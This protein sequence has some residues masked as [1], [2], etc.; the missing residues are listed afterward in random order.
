MA[1]EPRPRGISYGESIVVD[2][3]NVFLLISG[4]WYVYSK[5]RAHVGDGGMGSVLLGRRVADGMPVAIKRIHAEFANRGNVRERVR[6]E[7]QLTFAHP[8]LV[9]ILGCCEGTG[10]KAPIFVISKF[11]H[12]QTID[13]YV[14]SSF[15]DKATRARHLIPII[16][17]LTSAIDFIHAEGIIHLDIKPSNV[18]I[19]RGSTVKLLDLG[20]ADVAT[21]SVKTHGYGLHGTPGYAA[22]EQYI[23]ESN[24]ELIIDRRTD[25]YGLAATTYALITG[26]TP[27]PEDVPENENGI[28]SNLR[29]VFLKALAKE[30]E[31]RYAT[32]SEFANAFETA[33]IK[34]STP[35]KNDRW[36]IICIIGVIVIVTLLIS[37]FILTT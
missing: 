2:N 16:K 12:G 30:K 18:M 14:N 24:P 8:N 27:K 26:K 20:I 34:D 21:H 7:S 11:I 31:Q 23:D 35:E 9:E 32:A 13:V 36:L 15:P 28:G 33:A 22:P 6:L 5:R 29:N 4:R 19:E 17:Q 1:T 10:E 3:D 25:V 37:I